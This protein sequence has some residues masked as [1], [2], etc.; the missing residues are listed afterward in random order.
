MLGPPLP[1]R[2]RAARA[3]L[4]A[5]GAAGHVRGRDHGDQQRG[6]DPRRPTRCSRTGSAG[7]GGALRRRPG[8]RRVD[9]DLGAARRSRPSR[10]RVHAP[11]SRKFID[12]VE[13]LGLEADARR[14]EP[15]DGQ[16]PRLPGV[17]LLQHRLCLRAQAL[18]A[19]HPAALGAGRWAAGGCG[20]SP[21]ARSRGSSRGGRVEGI[22]VPARTGGKFGCG[23]SASWSPPGRSAPATCWGAAGSAGRRWARGLW[24]QH[25]LADHGRVRRARSTNYAGLQIT[26]V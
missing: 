3:R 2:R 23:P 21:S 15:I 20:S 1:R 17:R 16:H 25:R 22:S 7:C 8:A 10:T 14:Y 24:L 19:R 26:H 13:A 9:R 6:L 18:D 5:P 11:G 4:P 12:G